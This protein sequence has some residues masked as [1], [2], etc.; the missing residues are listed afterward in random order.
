MST[1]CRQE[2]CNGL[3]CRLSV[4]LRPVGRHRRAVRLRQALQNHLELSIAVLEQE[5][6]RTSVAL[7]ARTI[8]PGSP[9]SRPEGR[10]DGADRQS[11]TV[12]SAWSLAVRGRPERTPT[13]SQPTDV[14]DQ[15]GACRSRSSPD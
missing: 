1:S 2:A 12:D 3:Q 8:K 6:A 9:E 4:G 13:M 15:S 5:R 7:C 11:I 10:I 14:S